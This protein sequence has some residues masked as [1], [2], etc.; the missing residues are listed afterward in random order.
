MPP[1][2]NDL[3][4]DHII[5][6]RN[7]DH[8][9]NRAQVFMTAEV[10]SCVSALCVPGRK[11]MYSIDFSDISANAMRN[12]P[13]ADV[14]GFLLLSSNMISKLLPYRNPTTDINVCDLFGDCHV[15][16][17][18]AEDKSTRQVSPHESFY[19]KV[20]L[21]DKCSQFKAHWNIYQNEC[22]KTQKL[23]IGSYRWFYDQKLELRKH[24]RRIKEM[25]HLSL[26]SFLLCLRLT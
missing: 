8:L 10:F 6:D 11:V 4:N 22:K 26:F 21:C 9:P 25:F 12:H 7:E 3:F 23:L 16:K 20:N 14:S 1:D 17:D 18:A 2:L 13:S 24:I 5:T 19:L 15:G